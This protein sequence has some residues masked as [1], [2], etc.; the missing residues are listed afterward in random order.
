MK[1]LFFLFMFIPAIVLSESNINYEDGWWSGSW[2]LGKYFEYIT[3]A[4]TPT[5]TP[6]PT[7]TP[8]PTNTPNYDLSYLRLDTTNDPLLNPLRILGKSQI[9]SDG[10]PA[11]GADT[12]LF[13]DGMG[14]LEF[15]TKNPALN[16]YQGMA[17]SRERA[18]SG[19]KD[20]IGFIGMDHGDGLWVVSGTENVKVATGK[21]AGLYLTEE[22][23]VLS[24]DKAG[25]SITDNVV[26]LSYDPSGHA[27]VGTTGFGVDFHRGDSLIF[28]TY[29]FTPSTPVGTG[30]PTPTPNTKGYSFRVGS[31]G[32]KLDGLK[33]G[34]GYG[35]IVAYDSGTD[36]IGYR[37]WPTAIPSTPVPTNTPTP[38]STPT[39][40]L[41]DTPVAGDFL[42]FVTWPT[43]RWKPDKYDATPIW[44]ADKLQNN[45][46]KQVTP[47][48]GDVLTFIV[49]AGT[50]KWAPVTP[51]PTLAPP[52]PQP[53][54]D[55]PTPY[56]V[57][58]EMT[59][60]PTISHANLE[61]ILGDSS[62]IPDGSHYFITDGDTYLYSVAVAD[63][64]FFVS[65]YTPVFLPT[66]TPTPEPDYMVLK[67]GTSAVNGA[68]YEDGMSDGV[69]C[70]S[71][72]KAGN[73]WLYRYDERGVKYWAINSDKSTGHPRTK[74]YYKEDCSSHTPYLGGYDIGEG[75]VPGPSVE[76]TR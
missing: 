20:D 64:R 67:A 9:T 2:Y 1:K 48:P 13:V 17:F 41:S 70:Y 29:E 66:P 46:I 10:L 57:P 43:H 33:S 24:K 22:S 44:N 58:V 5:N 19:T 39:P 7:N 73:Y 38:T 60:E 40:F 18:G 21:G 36:K 4:P 28:Y 26:G 34:S 52:T 11:F 37:D 59:P 68:Y 8:T 61:A 16:D 15:S 65:G 3:P 55:T 32:H 75:A 25:L 74:L 69:P 71:L 53:I 76:G 35:K 31:D 49:D 72:N 12:R 50:P 42:R 23:A 63:A 45:L 30:T 56:H 54:P 62:E 47:T 51:I 27:G 14:Y 6:V